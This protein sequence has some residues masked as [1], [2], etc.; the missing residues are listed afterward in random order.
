MLLDESVY[1][2]KKSQMQDDIDNSGGTK[3]T[4]IHFDRS[5]MKTKIGQFGQN[6]MYSTTPLNN[7]IRLNQQSH[8]DI[9]DLASISSRDQAR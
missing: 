8:M 4:N 7:A 1:S 2:F 9:G 5:I 6:F 3:L